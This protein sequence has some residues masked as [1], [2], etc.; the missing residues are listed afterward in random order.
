MPHVKRKKKATK[1]MRTTLTTRR[2]W[3][4]TGDHVRVPGRLGIW[5]HGIV[6]CRGRG[7]I[8]VVHASKIAGV[9]LASS[10]LEFSGGHQI[11]LVKRA[12]KG[13]RL[14]IANRAR[15]MIGREYSAFGLNCEHVAYNASH[16]DQHSPQLRQVVGTLA[17][18]AL[19]AALKKR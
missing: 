5:H 9:V 11:E 19:V 4:R 6:D 1:K 14:E 8:K 13:E 16:E 15:A 7:G 2:S 3:L 12:A 10:L 18:L 17:G